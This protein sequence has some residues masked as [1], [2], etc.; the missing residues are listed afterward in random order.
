MRSFITALILTGLISFAYTADLV[1]NPVAY[2]PFDGNA[3]DESGNNF[4]ASVYGATLSADRYGEAD[5]A[6]YFDGYSAYMAITNNSAL[7]PLNAYTVSAWVNVTTGKTY[8]GI[9]NNIWDTGSDESGYGL[10]FTD[11]APRIGN[12]AST[13]G[14]SSWWT[15]GCYTEFELYKWTHIVGTFDGSYAKIYRDGQLVN[16]IPVSGD[17]KYNF[18]NSMWIG[19]YH[20][21]NEDYYFHGY[22]DEVRIYGTALTE[23]EVFALYES[24]WII[25]PN[26]SIAYSGSGP[27]LSWD[28]VT[29]ATSYN[30]FSSIDPNAAYPSESWTLE[31]NVTELIWTDPD[32]TGT[33]KFYIVV[34]V[35]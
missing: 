3:N 11:A 23:N 31:T 34:A 17:I 32:T 29:N 15:S 27:E 20:D 33:K 1:Q 10:C 35:K 26:A 28:P 6:Y 16:S 9:V 24:E 21:D 14:T 19:R 8:A 25:P 7:N 18:P 12:I 4:H 22:I 2:Y 5:K 30:I 13:T